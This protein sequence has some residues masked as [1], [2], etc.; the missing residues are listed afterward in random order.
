MSKFDSLYSRLIESCCQS[1]N[2]VL[3]LDHDKKI[4]SIC[5][6][7]DKDKTETKKWERKGYKLS[8]G[9]CQKCEESI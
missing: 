7:C 6:W 2:A 1:N 5:A 9:I 8:H 4:V 3:N